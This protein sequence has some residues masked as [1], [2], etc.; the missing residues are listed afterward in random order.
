[1]RRR[2]FIT[3]LGG[4][5][6]LWPLAG[7]AQQRKVPT[8]EEPIRASR[9]GSAGTQGYLWPRSSLG[10]GTTSFGGRPL[11]GFSRDWADGACRT[12]R[13]TRTAAETLV[14]SEGGRG[15]SSVTLR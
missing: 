1:M 3:L 6:T 2:K 9:R 12:G 8:I 10:G 4:A 15:P 7:I 13:R 11:R 5:A 14:E